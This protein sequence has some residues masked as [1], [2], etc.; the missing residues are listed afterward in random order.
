MLILRAASWALCRARR[1]GVA[2]I[3]CTPKGQRPALPIGQPKVL[4]AP[5]SAV[6]QAVPVPLEVGDLKPEKAAASSR[7]LPR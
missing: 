4:A 7:A 3:P 1:A 2:D 5:N 6:G